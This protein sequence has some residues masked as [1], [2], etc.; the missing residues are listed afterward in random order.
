MAAN[1][2]GLTY[3]ELRRWIARQ[4]GKDRDPTAWSSTTQ[5][6]CLDILKAG[7]RQF[8]FPPVQPVHVWSFLKPTLR[9]LTLHAAYDTG[10]VAATASTTV[11]LSG[12]GATWPSW[13]ADGELWVGG[14]WY[15]V[16][17]RTSNSQIVLASSVTIASG[18][19]YSLIHREYELPDE[20]AGMTAQ[21]TYR[22]DQTQT[23]AI[24]KV[25]EA[26]IRSMDVGQPI[27]GPPQ[28]VALVSRVPTSSQESKINAMFWP[29]PDQDYRVWYRADVIPPMLDGSSYVYPHGGAQYQEAI[30][31]SCL[32]KALQ[33]LYDSYEKHPAFLET[34]SAAIAYDRKLNQA[35]T[36]GFGV[37][38][39]GYCRA[40]GPP[41][42]ATRFGTLT[43][44]IVS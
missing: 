19:S 31:A 24:K 6:D 16:S 5:T 35:D 22:R 20:V 11:T 1:T 37:Y 29:I 12:T 42:V 26:Y 40:G 8:Y 27:T 30:L 10:T 25:N 33:T 14:E 44:D 15:Q 34:V 2:L 43:V 32:D 17:S 3:T 21:F 4:I 39:D 36:A 41:A 9:E 7:L 28:Y 13:A 38:S 23:D 18:T